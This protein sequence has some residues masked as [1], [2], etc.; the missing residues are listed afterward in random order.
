M[1]KKEKKKKDH[2]SF[3]KIPGGITLILRILSD[4]SIVASHFIRF[5]M[6][7]LSHFPPDPHPKD[8][9]RWSF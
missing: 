3:L 8:A 9:C 7:T 1:R 4:R 5:S 2:S 6:A